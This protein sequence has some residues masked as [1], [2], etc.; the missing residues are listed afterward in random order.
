MLS[1]LLYVP[2]TSTTPGDMPATDVPVM[3]RTVVAMQGGG[4]KADQQQNIL[5][6]NNTFC[7]IL[8]NT[9][10]TTQDYFSLL[11]PK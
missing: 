6:S 8:S 11:T 10:L 9:S 3:L 5:S 4:V 2:T 7:V 1:I